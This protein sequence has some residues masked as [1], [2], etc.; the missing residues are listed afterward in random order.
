[1]LLFS[2]NPGLIIAELSNTRERQVASQ[3]FLVLGV[4]SPVIVFQRVLQIIYG[5][6]V[7]DYYLQG[8]VIVGNIVKISSVFFFF[9]QGG[10]S[11]YGTPELNVELCLCW[12]QDT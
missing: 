4:F 7:E 1:M 2:F 6:R 3:L 11:Y 8:V 12:L 10:V 9:R 5:V